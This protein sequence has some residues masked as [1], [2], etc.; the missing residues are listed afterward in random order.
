MF[1]F[2]QAFTIFLVQVSSDQKMI[3]FK[4]LFF[5]V[6]GS[7][8]THTRSGGASFRNS[9][10]VPDQRRNAVQH[11]RMVV[12]YGCPRRVCL[13]S[14]GYASLGPSVGKLSVRIQIIR[15]HHLCKYPLIDCLP[16]IF[17]KDIPQ[18]W[19]KHGALVDHIFEIDL[20]GPSAANPTIG[21]TFPEPEGDNIDHLRVKFLGSKLLHQSL[22]SYTLKC[23]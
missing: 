11:Q 7:I 14:V 3:L 2:N 23:Y 20:Y 22:S 12:V 10:S 1:L 8:R 15:V 17:I 9:G 16:C 21:A 19:S 13:G 18:R 5:F 4:F 6:H